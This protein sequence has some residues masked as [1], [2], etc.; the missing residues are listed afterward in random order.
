M[1]L[2]VTC[3]PH[4]LLAMSCCFHH[5]ALQSPSSRGTAA[6]CMLKRRHLHEQ[7]CSLSIAT[8]LI[9]LAFPDLTCL[10]CARGTTT[11]QRADA[12]RVSQR[13]SEYELDRMRVD[14]TAASFTSFN[15]EEGFGSPAPRRNRDRPTVFDMDDNDLKV[16][17]PAL[18]CLLFMKPDRYRCRG[19]GFH[20]FTAARAI[21][22]CRKAC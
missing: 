13:S 11:A 17:N 20:D 8:S 2:S 4:V 10:A 6:V 22:K 14:A 16:S 3:A 21:L 1:T 18:T 7:C 19:E 12:V 15:S 9:C 5:A